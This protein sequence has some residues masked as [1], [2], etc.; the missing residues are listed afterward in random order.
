MSTVLKMSAV[1]KQQFKLIRTTKGIKPQC[2]NFI[3]LTQLV[4]AT[5]KDKILLYVTSYNRLLMP[6]RHSQH[7]SIS[8]LKP[9]KERR[10]KMRFSQM[11][12]LGST[13]NVHLYKRYRW[14][15]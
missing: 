9:L 5:R 14:I 4:A 8:E 15:R 3:S 1:D 2:I 13:V 7:T 6:Y 11:T 12:K 10:P